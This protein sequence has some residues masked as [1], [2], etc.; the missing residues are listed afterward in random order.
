M[1]VHLYWWAET[2]ALANLLFCYRCAGF[3]LDQGHKILYISGEESP[4]QIK[5]RAERLGSF[6]S[7]LYVLCETDLG[8]VSET[9]AD[10]KP[11]TSNN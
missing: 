1:L 6:S 5:M 10:T 8:V 9:I 2:L 3:C 11:G 4:K 7:N